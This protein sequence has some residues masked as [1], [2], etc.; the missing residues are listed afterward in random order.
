MFVVCMYVY[1]YVYIH[2]C[3]YVHVCIKV[4]ACMC[5]CLQ[6]ACTSYWRCPQ[7]TETSALSCSEPDPIGWGDRPNGVIQVTEH[8]EYCPL[9]THRADSGRDVVVGRV[10]P[11]PGVNLLLQQL[12]LKYGTCSGVVWVP[13]IPGDSPSGGQRGGVAL[14]CGQTLL[15]SVMLCL[16]SSL[17]LS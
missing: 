5:V 7:S 8:T 3:T 4:H 15:L 9:H 13:T 17:F 14:S 2:V 10:S 11:S 1:T 6:C 16:S 12:Y